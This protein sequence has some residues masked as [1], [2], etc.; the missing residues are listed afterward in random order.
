MKKNIENLLIIL[1]HVFIGYL[2]FAFVV[3][4][5]DLNYKYIGGG[6]RLFIVMFL[7][8]LVVIGGSVV[9]VERGDD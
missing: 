3:Q 4:S 9:N 5:W 8:G 1:A 2:L 7:I 6:G